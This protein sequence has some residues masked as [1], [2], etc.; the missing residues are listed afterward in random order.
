[1]SGSTVS[2]RVKRWFERSSGFVMVASNA[3]AA[4]GPIGL[5]QLALHDLADGAAR[6]RV[7][8]LDADQPLGLAELVVGPRHDLGLTDRDAVAAHAQRHRRLAPLLA[9]NADHR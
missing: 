9:R 2:D 6:K 3:G 8:K 7:A 5:A 4:A 1:M